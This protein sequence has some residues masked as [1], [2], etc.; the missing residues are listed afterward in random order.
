ML[1]TIA[2]AI[3]TV[4]DY[5]VTEEEAAEN[6]RAEEERKAAR[7]AVKAAARA[8][9]ELRRKAQLVVTKAV[10]TGETPVAHGSISIDPP[11]H[12]LPSVRVVY[13]PS[14]EE[15]EAA[16]AAYRRREAEIALRTLIAQKRES[17]P[18]LPQ[19]ILWVVGAGFVHNRDVGP[20]AI[21]ACEGVEIVVFGGAV[22]DVEER[23]R[24]VKPITVNIVV[25]NL[26][27]PAERRER[28]KAI[29]EEARRAKQARQAEFKE[30]RKAAAKPAE[31]KKNNKK[32]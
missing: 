15:Q 11:A 22:G 9:K 23:H 20:N 14:E 6:R 24:K 21:Y 13:L 3:R 8:A 7:A 1:Q 5:T 10:G 31:S 32:K 27:S 28:N 4:Y 29:A 19:F 2:P 16:K 26:F 30:R 17:N 18:T 12:P 25:D